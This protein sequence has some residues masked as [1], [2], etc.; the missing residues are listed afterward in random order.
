MKILPVFNFKSGNCYNKN[1]LNNTKT[2]PYPFDSVSFGKYQK[3][4]N[5]NYKTLYKL[6]VL[7]DLASDDFN[8]YL[9]SLELNDMI[10]HLKALGDIE[11]KLP[12]LKMSEENIDFLASQISKKAFQEY[13]KAIDECGANIFQLAN[14]SKLEQICK[15]LTKPA[16]AVGCFHS[17]CMGANAF[18]MARYDKDKVEFLADTLDEQKYLT[19][20]LIK[21]D[22]W[23]SYPLVDY[24]LESFYKLA[25][26]IDSESAK[27]LLKSKMNN[28]K[29]HISALDYDKVKYMCEKLQKEDIKQLCLLK[30]E[31]GN[32]PLHIQS[33]KAKRY[34]LSKFDS[35]DLIE[36]LNL[37]NAYDVRVKDLV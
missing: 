17:N 11:H 3:P 20:A 12:L 27:M 10:L 5:Y 23:Q 26:N 2:A 37:K 8:N 19:S 34:L 6:S 18:H 14:K 9:R 15:H 7:Y 35:S 1:N 32:S 30:D 33:K 28:G 13:T 36:L 25:K 4:A 16:I 24:P 21:K 31:W 29:Y 22:G